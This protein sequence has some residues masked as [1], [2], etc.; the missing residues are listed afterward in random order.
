[1]AASIHRR[2][3]CRVL[4]VAQASV[5]AWLAWTFRAEIY[6]KLAA[7]V[8]CRVLFLG[9]SLTA[10]GGV[11]SWKL[12]RW[13]P[14]T[15]NFGRSGADLYF[16]KSIADENVPVVKPECVV[17]MA[18]INDF[19]RGHDVTTIIRDYEA[20]IALIRQTKSVRSLIIVSTLY[21][22]D[23]KHTPEIDRLNE[24]L[25]ALCD[26][27]KLTFLDLRPTLC[28]DGRLLPEFS[29]DVVHLNDEGR[30]VWAREL[31]SV[32]NKLGL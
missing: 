27:E 13:W 29:R 4:L 17:I 26:R 8:Q 11:W 18:G 14:D 31:A 7:R 2:R 22:R 32:L 15:R 12:G 30:R 1:M 16:V 3:F 23:G 10:E 5:I 20:A 24:A 9:D 21:L 28:R 25:R 6:E 19:G